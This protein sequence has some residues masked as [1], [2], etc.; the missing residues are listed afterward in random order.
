M[1]DERQ[2]HCERGA[3]SSR[4]TFINRW[5]RFFWRHAVFSVQIRLH[6]TQELLSK[7]PFALLFGN[8]SPGILGRY[9]TRK[10]WFSRAFCVAVYEDYVGLAVPADDSGSHNKSVT[11]PALYTHSSYNGFRFYTRIIIEQNNETR[12]RG[13]SPINCCRVLQQ[14]QASKQIEMNRR[15]WNTR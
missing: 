5:R 12:E 4:A 3:D 13:S 9:R 11:D 10:C 7:L 8:H 14:S 1:H 15:K 2:P 6:D